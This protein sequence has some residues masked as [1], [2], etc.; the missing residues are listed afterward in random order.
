MFA[1]IHVR[2]SLHTFP[3]LSPW[4]GVGWGW[5]E[6]IGLGVWC[7]EEEKGGGIRGFRFEWR[8]RMWA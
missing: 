1:C 6:E 8:I 7:R 5:V 4:V 3:R 2:V